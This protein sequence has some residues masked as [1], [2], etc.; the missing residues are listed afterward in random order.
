MRFWADVEAFPQ[1]FPQAHS[2]W[3]SKHSRKFVKS[4][5]GGEVFA[6]SE[7]GDHV[8]MICV[9][10]CAL[11]RPLSGHAGSWGLREPIHTPQGQ[12]DSHGEVFGSTPPD[13]QQALGTQE[14]DNVY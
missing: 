2:Q 5:L 3:T 7:M 13:H 8:P 4:S 11:L 1:A 12:A 9:S 6:F 14:L 10:F